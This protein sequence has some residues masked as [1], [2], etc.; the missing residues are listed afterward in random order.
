M[1]SEILYSTYIWSSSKRMFNFLKSPYFGMFS[2]PTSTVGVSVSPSHKLK[3][4]I[5][6]INYILEKKKESTKR[7]YLIHTNIILSR[8]Y[9]LRIHIPVV[10]TLGKITFHLAYFYDTHVEHCITK[11][12]ISNCTM[13]ISA[14]GTTIFLLSLW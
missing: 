7:C 6:S 8:T 5:V 13:K 1:S 9:F 10:H 11:K 12:R 3:L 14:T 2:I 4:Q